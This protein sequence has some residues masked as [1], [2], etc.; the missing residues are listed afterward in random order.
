MPS[1][2]GTSDREL[3]TIPIDSTIGGVL[4]NFGNDLQ[5]KLIQSLKDKGA[6]D[7]GNLAQTIVFETEYLGQSWE[8]QLSMDKRGEF[9]DEC[10]RG[11]GESSIKAKDHKSYPLHET[12]GRFSFKDT[13]T[14]KPS[15]K[16]FFGWAQ[17]K[18]ISPFV[19][20]ESVFRKGLKANHFYSDVV[21]KQL[22]DNLKIELGKAGAKEI[23]IAVTI[24]SNQLGGSATRK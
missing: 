23:A 3:R 9:L 14:G 13:P 19:V 16:H 20:R 24:K 6:Y 18:G 5:K 8:F 2:L 21:N 10:V 11:V 12:S 15:A 22:I 4:Q 7:S 1:F 17:R